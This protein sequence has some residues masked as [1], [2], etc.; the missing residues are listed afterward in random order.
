LYKH[1]HSLLLAASTF[2]F[3]WFRFLYE[4]VCP[5][6][7]II[8]SVLFTLAPVWRRRVKCWSGRIDEP[9]GV[10]LA[11]TYKDQLLLTTQVLLGSLE[12]IKKAHP[13]V[14]A[15]Q[16]PTLVRPMGFPD[17]IATGLC[18]FIRPTTVSL[19]IVIS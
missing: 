16:P 3:S 18:S 17:V 14:F 19:P 5:R 12:Q 2:S 13:H 15:L 6:A 7:K 1:I 8:H 4:K 11:F 9:N 10:L